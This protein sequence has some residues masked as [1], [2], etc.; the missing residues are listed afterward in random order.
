VTGGRPG[1][2]FATAAGRGRYF[3]LSN[4]V[5]PRSSGQRDGFVRRLDVNPRRFVSAL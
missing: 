2:G 3:D 5:K 1:T 4:L